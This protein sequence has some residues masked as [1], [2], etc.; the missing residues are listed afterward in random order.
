MKPNWI[1]FDPASPDLPPE[2]R[3]VLVLVSDMGREGCPP[4]VAAAYLRIHSGGPFFV[5]PGVAHTRVTH[6]ADCLG[7][8]FATPVVLN[9]HGQQWQMTNG[10]WGVFEPASLK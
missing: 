2:R 10:K 1:E 9:K 8:D 6:Y 5:V 3:N 7:D 4:T